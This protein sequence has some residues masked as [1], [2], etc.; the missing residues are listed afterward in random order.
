MS[1]AA[2]TTR[3]RLRWLAA[4]AVVIVAA[5][6]AGYFV[7]SRPAKLTD[8]NTI[9]LGDFTN[10]TGDSVFDDTLKQGLS[11]QLLGS[12]PFSTWFPSTR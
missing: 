1:R 9:V 11:V 2:P 6:V 12:R 5:V 7:S 4:A 3:R 10:T 8:K